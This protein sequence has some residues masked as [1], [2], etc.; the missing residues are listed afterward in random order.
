MEVLDVHHISARKLDVHPIQS[1]REGGCRLVANAPM[2]N[3]ACSISLEGDSIEAP[4]GS[5]VSHTREAED[6]GAGSH[7]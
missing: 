7:W 5:G 3:E 1:L 6:V 4:R 2:A